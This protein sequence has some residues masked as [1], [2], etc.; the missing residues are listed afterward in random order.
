MYVL[1]SCSYNQFP[2]LLDFVFRHTI[3]VIRR[4]AFDGPGVIQPGAG[5]QNYGSSRRKSALNTTTHPFPRLRGMTDSTL[6]QPRPVHITSFY[7]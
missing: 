3:R 1:V 6:R 2:Y 7:F 4:T 5:V